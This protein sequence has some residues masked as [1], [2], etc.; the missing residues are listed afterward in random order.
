MSLG[1]I[2]VSVLCGSG[3]LG[4]LLPKMGRKAPSKYFLEDSEFNLGPEANMFKRFLREKIGYHGI[5][6]NILKTCSSDSFFQQT[7]MDS[8][9][10]TD[11]GN[12][13]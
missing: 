2:P 8:R 3:A 11:S 12:E 1:H 9:L 6:P 5:L 13:F 7:L 10:A 4:I